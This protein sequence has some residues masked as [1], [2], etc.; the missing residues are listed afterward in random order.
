[1]K[2]I[3]TTLN[4]LSHTHALSNSFAPTRIKIDDEYEIELSEVSYY[5]KTYQYKTD[6]AIDCHLFYH[7][8]N[9]ANLRS[10]PM[11]HTNPSEIDK[12]VS[13][14]LRSAR[15]DMRTMQTLGFERANP[16]LSLY[17]NDGY[18]IEMRLDDTDYEFVEDRFIVCFMNEETMFYHNEHVTSPDRTFYSALIRAVKNIARHRFGTEFTTRLPST[19]LDRVI[20]YEKSR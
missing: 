1:M 2:H 5:D 16:S 17:I 9:V 12:D 8:L 15:R 10:E 20:K 18:Y 19:L 11:E 6:Y 14:L 13:E 4:T 7:G 3:L